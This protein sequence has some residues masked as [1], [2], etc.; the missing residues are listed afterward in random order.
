[1]W[2][3]LALLTAAS[4]HVPPFQ[5]AAMTFLIGGLAG[6]ATWP[7]RR[8]AVS[9]TRDWS[10]WLLG[11]AGLFGYHFFYFSAIRTA[12]PIEVSLIV[13]AALLPGERLK[14]HHV[15]DVVLN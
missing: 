10:A 6:V 13:F 4:G 12:P 8:A 5:L 14:P 15:A 1:M 11:V 7:F 3:S 9:L 2:A